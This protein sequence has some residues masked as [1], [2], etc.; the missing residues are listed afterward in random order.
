LISPSKGNDGSDGDNDITRLSRLDITCSLLPD[1]R[2]S[3][4]CHSPCKKSPT[5]TLPMILHR[6]LQRLHLAGRNTLERMSCC[7]RYYTA[8]FNSIPSRLLIS[9]PLK[10]PARIA[11]RS[12]AESCYQC[13]ARKVVIYAFTRSF[14]SSSRC[15]VVAISLSLV[16]QDASLEDSAANK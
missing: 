4:S 3:P 16:L 6:R 12:S 8:S 1:R 2:P 14:T 11:S 15:I 9:R 13:I 5:H 7:G 10:S